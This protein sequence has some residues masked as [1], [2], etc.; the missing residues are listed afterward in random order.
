RERNT[1]IHPDNRVDVELLR[2][3]QQQREEFTTSPSS[4]PASSTTT[5]RSTSSL[6]G[7]PRHDTCPICLNESTYSVE[8][9]CGH[10]FCGKC[11]ISYWRFQPNWL[12][13]MRCPVT[14]LLPCFTAD[15]QQ[16]TDV[17]KQTI[18]NDYN[19]FNRRFSGAPRTYLKVHPVYLEYIR[20]I[21]V[22]IPH[23]IR[24]IF[25]VHGIQWAYRLRFIT[26]FLL[27][28][29]YVI[30]PFDLL[31]ESAIGILGM[32]DDLFLFLCMLIYASVI[33]RQQLSQS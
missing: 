16:S 30:S 13:G 17:D 5:T 3:R 10:L 1:T 21:P 29:A 20:D 28:I 18:I 2:E 26:I 24:Q 14:V 7:Q 25:S 22:L 12:A 33:Y 9:N 27:V 31:P 15:E 19:D 23:L 8:T 6:L 4:S 11:L 32:L